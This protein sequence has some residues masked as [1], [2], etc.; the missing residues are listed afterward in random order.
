MTRDDLVLALREVGCAFAEEEADQVLRHPE[1]EPAEVVGRRAA[2]EPL[3]QILRSVTLGGLDLHVGPGLFVP[4]QRTALLASLAVAACRA[5]PQAVFVE[6][7]CGAAP[8]AASVERADVA[9]V[10]VA[11]DVDPRCVPVASSNLRTTLVASGDLF[12]AVPPTLRGRLDVVAAV[13][14]YVP[15]GDVGLLPAEARDHEPGAALAAGDD[16]LDVVR[17]LL[18]LAPGWLSPRGVLLL[19]MGRTQVRAATDAAARAGLRPQRVDLR[20]DR[21]AVVTSAMVSAPATT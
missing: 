20:P 6:L 1:V 2:G 11:T 21:T 9:A 17:R 12:D 8:V 3:E 19:E 5:R 16:G 7:C 10:V 13:P 18:D 4:R 14:P 15:A